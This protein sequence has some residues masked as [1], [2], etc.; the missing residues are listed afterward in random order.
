[1]GRSKSLFFPRPLTPQP[2]QPAMM[3]TSTSPQRAVNHRLFDT[4]SPRSRRVFHRAVSICVY[5][6]TAGPAAPTGATSPDGWPSVWTA[7]GQPPAGFVGAGPD[8]VVLL[9]P[10]QPT[11]DATLRAKTRAIKRRFIVLLLETVA[12]G[13]NNREVPRGAG[14]SCPGPSVRGGSRSP[15]RFPT[16]HRPQPI[17]RLRVVARAPGRYGRGVPTHSGIDTKPLGLFPEK[18][19]HSE[20]FL[21]S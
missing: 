19:L 9:P 6:K 7:S 18:I 2:P 17:P 11:I 12:T 20:F 16:P 15:S 21:I 13:S 10:P 8:L 4:S 3:T 14:R 5:E 1:M